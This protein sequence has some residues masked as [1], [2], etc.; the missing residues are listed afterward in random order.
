MKIETRRLLFFVS[1]VVALPVLANH[2][3]PV[4]GQF[5]ARPLQR[6]RATQ[7]QVVLIS[8][9]TL[10]N[11]VDPDLMQQSLGGR[12][13][14]L[15]WHGGAASASWYLTLKNYVVASGT[16]PAL[17]CVLFR[18]RMLTE[19]AFRTTGPYRGKI[20][21]Q[22]HE[23]EPVVDL[24]LGAGASGRVSRARWVDTIFPLN[25]RRHVQQEKIERTV[26]RWVAASGVDVNAVERKVN[27]TF[28]L[29]HL[30]AEAADEAGAISQQPEASFGAD[31]ARSFLPH[32]VDL[33][34]AN[35]MRLCFLRVKRYPESD[36]RVAQS[37]ALRSYMA[38]LRAYLESRGCA[39]ID[40]AEEPARTADMFL[41]PGDDHMSAEAKARSTELYAQK[42][43][44]L[45]PQ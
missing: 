15:L 34:V 33:A 4:R 38:E 20:E 43:R 39:F 21:T 36:G 6:L 40:D 18:D 3:L 7:P 13:V 16:G 22:M 29:A 9:S 35:Q 45:L 30:R 12:K 32:M 26:F 11:G 42:L 31:P 14:E 17:V 5:D 27:G 8:D 25:K 41:R 23:S 44:S 24:V 2:S 28:A 19:P 10:D 37:D 1:V